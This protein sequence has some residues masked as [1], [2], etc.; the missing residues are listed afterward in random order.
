MKP[1][2]TNLGIQWLTNFRED[3]QERALRLLDT[4]RFIS[5]SEMRVGPTRLSRQT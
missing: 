4:L 1:I 2:E 3:D 5:H